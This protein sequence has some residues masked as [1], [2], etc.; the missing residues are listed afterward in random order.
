ME[1]TVNGEKRS[2]DKP[3]SVSSLINTL[4]LTEAATIVEHNGQ[5]LKKSL[6]SDTLIGEGDRL[7]LIQL[8]GGG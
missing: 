8:V 1:V 7:E 3:L 6:F 2:F 5:V 4:E